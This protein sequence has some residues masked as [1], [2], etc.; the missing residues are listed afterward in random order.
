MENLRGDISAHV[1]TAS[2]TAE[3]NTGRQQQEHATIANWDIPQPQGQAH[4]LVAPRPPP[5]VPFPLTVD[6]EQPGIAAA[7]V[8]EDGN[9]GRSPKQEYGESGRPQP[10]W[11]QEPSLQKP[12]TQTQP[13][14]PNQS[15]KPCPC[16]DNALSAPPIRRKCSARLTELHQST[17]EENII[18]RAARAA[19]DELKARMEE[20]K[21]ALEERESVAKM[22]EQVHRA[23]VERLKEAE[24]E[25][26]CQW[27]R[28]VTY[29]YLDWDS[30]A[31]I[32]S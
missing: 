1:A 7:R 2:G 22:A 3:C 28:P 23:A 6:E 9:L 11:A 15:E 16:D 20:L 27:V 8:R 25:E 12:Q 4:E 17:E 32:S 26:P 14:R 19:A 29:S 21:R 30:I 5:C 18:R 13:Q 31:N 10:P 24:L